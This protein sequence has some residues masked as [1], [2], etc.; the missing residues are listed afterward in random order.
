M[1]TNYFDYFLPEHLIAQSP[2]ENRSSSRLL[3]LDKITGE[4]I[5]EK[6]FNIIN[7]L[8]KGDVLVLNNTKVIPSRI[9]AIKDDTKASIEILLLKEIDNDVYE[10]LAKKQKRLKIGTKL[11]FSDELTGTVVDLK[12][13]GI[14]YIKFDYKGVFLEII[15]KIGVM[16]LPPYIH[17][18]LNDKDRYNT[19]YSKINGSAAAPTA[20]LHFTN[21]L[22]KKIEEK[23]IEILYVT[24]HVGLGTFRPVNVEDVT[25]HVMHSEEYEITEEVA[26]KLNKAKSEKRRIVCVGTTSVRTLESN[27]SKYGKFT[28]TKEET[29]IFIYPGY[30][31]KAVNS[32]ITN[33]HLP[34]ST[35][36]MLVSALSSKEIIMDAYK[37]AINNNYRFFSF[38]DAMFITNLNNGYKNIIKKVNSYK[39]ISYNYFKIIKGNNNILVSAPHAYKHTRNGEMKTNEYNTSN[40]VKILKYFTNVHIIYT[41]KATNEDPNFDVKNEYKNVVI[42]YIKENNIKYFID[43]HGFFDSKTDLI[44]GMN[45]KKNINND[46]N[47]LENIYNIFYYDFS[48]KIL[49]DKKYKASKNALSK[50]VNE[51]TGVFALQFEINK[52]FRKMKR[53]RNSFNKTIK[54]FISII[55]YIEGR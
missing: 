3:V 10:C 24:L 5:H 29:S 51:K 36:L 32:L 4:I 31:Y 35:L 45:N 53:R 26:N 2:L 16:P 18:K 52:N 19:V 14:T 23:G 37:E 54:S 50:C 20:G 1:K 15:S 7:Y 41:D 49:V 6:F 43:I 27:I 48:T 12:E 39:K 44:I 9:Y 8:N 47:L 17:K 30:K 28:K 40:I 21:E 33:F 42:N 25:K 55:K 11:M 46:C 13:E 22:L 34:K 38:G